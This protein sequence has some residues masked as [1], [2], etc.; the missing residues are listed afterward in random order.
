[1]VGYLR[2]NLSHIDKMLNSGKILADRQT[3]RLETIRNIYQQR[4]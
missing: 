1:M 4:N 3:E 2:R